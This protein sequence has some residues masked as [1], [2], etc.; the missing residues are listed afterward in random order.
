MP[1]CRGSR[2]WTTLGRVSARLGT[3]RRAGSRGKFITFQLAVHALARRA[4]PPAAASSG[5]TELASSRAE[6]EGGGARARARAGGPP[7]DATAPADDQ[8]RS[9]FS[10]D[11]CWNDKRVARARQKYETRA[12]RHMERRRRRNCPRPRKKRAHVRSGEVLNSKSPLLLG[13][14][15]P[16]TRESLRSLLSDSRGVK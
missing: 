1:K 16:V 7:I 2:A 9:R 14:S 12:I 8:S 6:S 15:T 5:M 3:T 4:S 13:T 11:R 10:I